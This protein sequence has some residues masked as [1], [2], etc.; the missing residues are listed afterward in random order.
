M[1]GVHAF[2]QVD[3]LSSLLSLQQAVELCSQRIFH[4][5]SQ[6]SEY[7]GSCGEAAP[8][9]QL[10]FRRSFSRN[11]FSERENEIRMDRHKRLLVSSK[12]STP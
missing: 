5:E 11:K 10:I 3:L 9:F 2:V 6:Y 1:I 12:Y 7:G 4:F 8:I